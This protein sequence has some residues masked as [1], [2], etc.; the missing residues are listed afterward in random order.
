MEEALPEAFHLAPVRLPDQLVD[1]SLNKE[2]L[3]QWVYPSPPQRVSDEVA[4]AAYYAGRAV[5][6]IPDIMHKC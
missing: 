2:G 1:P 6:R 5:V 3:L 4:T